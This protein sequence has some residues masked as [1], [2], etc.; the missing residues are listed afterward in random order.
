L[1]VPRQCEQA[2]KLTWLQWLQV[3][4]YGQLFARMGMGEGQMLDKLL[5][6]EEAKRCKDC[7][8]QQFHYAVFYAY[9]RLAE[10]EI[11]NLMW[12][13]ECVAQDQKARINDG[14]CLLF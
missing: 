3:P 1:V 12:I 11:R 10:Q 2:K 8:D 6:E 13:S 5:Y 14:I 7:Y 9:M 4:Q